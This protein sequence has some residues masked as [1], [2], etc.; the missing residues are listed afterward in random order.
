MD[1]A[2]FQQYLDKYIDGALDK[3]KTVEF[4]AYIN[5]NPDMKQELEFQKKVGKAVKLQSR[6]NLYSELTVIRSEMEEEVTGDKSKTTPKYMRY[7]FWMLPV[8]LILGSVC[9]YLSNQE[10]A[11]IE[12]VMPIASIE[13]T[14][15]AIDVALQE[16]LAMD[17]D[18]YTQ[19]AFASETTASD[20]QMA[21]ALVKLKASVYD[22]PGL[23]VTD[24]QRAYLKLIEDIKT[25]S[26]I[27]AF[28]KLQ[29]IKGE[30]INV[31][32]KYLFLALVKMRNQ[33]AEGTRM[34]R[35]IASAGGPYASIA[36]KVMGDE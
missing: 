2:T 19:T 14:N 17:I 5:Q 31:D 9:Y 32:K 25:N 26:K 22:E 15:A 20:A 3:E 21:E 12:A 11:N 4:E 34:I 16:I 29:S 8:L 24:E 1:K 6:Q 13:K 7:I 30:N 27:Q 36:L 23:L 10:E 28:T 33:E 35:E 18:H